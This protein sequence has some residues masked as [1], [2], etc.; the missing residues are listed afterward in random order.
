MK[1]K[2]IRIVPLM[3]ALTVGVLD[4]GAVFL[5]Y[6]AVVKLLSERS[7]FNIAFGVIEALL[8]VVSFTTTVQLFNNGVMFHA[9]S[10]EFTGVDDNNRFLYKNIEK[11]KTH[12]DTG[13]SFKK[14]F[15]DRYSSVIIYLNDGT[16]AT[17][18]L[19]FTSKRK[20]SKIED[21]LNK[22]IALDYVL[23]SANENE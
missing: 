14:N 15:V 23:K 7:F 5:G 3:S 16:V 1:I 22:R 8:L 20:L 11:I 6:F 10:V 2:F 13:V 19:G 12:K 18:E 21:E 17:I 4:F 9:K